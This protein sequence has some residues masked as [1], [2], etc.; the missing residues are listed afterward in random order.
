MKLRSHKLIPE[1]TV[2]VAAVDHA[3]AYRSV[4]VSDVRRLGHQLHTDLFCA[5]AGERSGANRK[6]RATGRRSY[7]LPGAYAI[8]RGQIT[9]AERDYLY[10]VASVGRR[11][12][13][14]PTPARPESGPEGSSAEQSGP[15]RGSSGLRA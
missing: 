4:G 14:E 11:S 2:V 10:S 5:V 15:S 9:E 3:R 1:R 13:A 6:R 7:V 12:P 8:M